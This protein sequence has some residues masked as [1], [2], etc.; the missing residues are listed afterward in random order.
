MEANRAKGLGINL[1]TVITTN[2]QFVGYG[3]A[4]LLGPNARLPVATGC[5]LENENAM[6]P[7][8]RMEANLVLVLGSCF[9]IASRKNALE[10][11]GVGRTGV[12]A[13]EPVDQEGLTHVPAPV[14]VASYA[15]ERNTRRKNVNYNSVQNARIP[16][17]LL[18]F[19]TDPEQLT[20]PCGAR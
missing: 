13:R 10:F 2:A 17:T 1:L 3:Q 7:K 16:R 12:N 6:T 5:S 8:Q 19:W 11:W 4:G 18:L 20:S 14:R 9:K 15:E